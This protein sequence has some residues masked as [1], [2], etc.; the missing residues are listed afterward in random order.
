M[1]APAETF[2]A[3]AFVLTS[4]RAA[5]T[6]AVPTWS[7]LRTFS[8]VMDVRSLATSAQ[9]A[10]VPVDADAAA[11]GGASEAVEGDAATE[12]AATEGAATEGAADAAVDGAV[13]VV[14][15]LQ[16]PTR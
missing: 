10:A 1:A 6:P 11:D 12:G 16:A 4:L 3:S 7:S 14:A 2:S 8:A 13:E 15:V 5:V 9:T